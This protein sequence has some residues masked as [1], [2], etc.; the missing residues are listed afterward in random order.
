[1]TCY[2]PL[3]AYYSN[4]INPATG[5]RQIT[6]KEKEAYLPSLL[7]PL[8]LPCGQC[9]GCRLDRSRNNAV[10]IM[11]E[12]QLH[13]ESIF[14][15]LTY[16]DEY[17]PPNN[18]VYVDEVQRFIKRL[19]KY[20][21][22][23]ENKKIRYFACGE[24]GTDSYRPHYHLI[25]FGWKPKDAKFYKD[26][27]AGKLYTSRI[28]EKI[29]KKGFC[30]FGEVTLESAA[31][32]ARYVCKKITGPL[33]EF[34]YNGLGINPEFCVRSSRPGLAHDWFFRHRKEA[35][36]DDYVIVNSKKLSLPKYFSRLLE[37]YLPE[38]LERMKKLRLEKSA[39]AIKKD[40]KTRGLVIPDSVKRGSELSFKA[41]DKI[42]HDW[43]VAPVQ[44]IVKQSQFKQLRRDEI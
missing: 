26:S 8:K 35:C 10:Q 25:I 38:E 43:H 18:S 29:W 9:I 28:L 36:R 37:R 39:Y 40:L 19:R 6:F 32:C 22:K 44:E 4:E 42:Y 21:D 2:H 15:T 34:Y 24:Y 1:M 3:T 33:A 11:L 41:L 13:D 7:N 23:Y 20:L 12:N 27:V 30:P 31:Y 5:K 14:L 16:D 17:L